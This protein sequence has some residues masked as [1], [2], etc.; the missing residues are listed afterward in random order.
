MS[1]VLFQIV[2][3]AFPIC[4]FKK[5]KILLLNWISKVQHSWGVKSVTPFSLK[6]LLAHLHCWRVNPRWWCSETCSSSHITTHWI[7]DR[8]S[9][10]FA[11]P[12]S[13]STQSA[14]CSHKGN[15]LGSS[16]K[17]QTTGKA[18]RTESSCKTTEKNRGQRNM[19][20]SFW[21]QTCGLSLV[22]AALFRGTGEGRER[23]T[24]LRKTRTGA[25]AKEWKKNLPYEMAAEHE[26]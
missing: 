1:K 3:S 10:G 9:S 19:G 26:E 25:A 2:P 7:P 24:R 14:Q 11:A 6:Y 13:H 5:N 17:T 8:E 18:S 21:T 16:S 23:H 15:L 20:C 22:I 4:F 12:C